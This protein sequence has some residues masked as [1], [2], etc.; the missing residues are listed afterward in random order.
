MVSG[1]SVHGAL[2][3]F[4]HIFHSKTKVGV[5]FSDQSTSVMMHVYVVHTAQFN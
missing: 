1:L 3:N 2:E 5:Y 4:V